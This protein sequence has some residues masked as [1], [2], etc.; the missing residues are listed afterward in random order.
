MMTDLKNV[1]GMKSGKLMGI[2]AIYDFR[3]DQDTGIGNLAIRRIPCACNGCLEQLDSVWKT[4]TVDKE[5]R[6]CKTSD[7]DKMKNIFDGLN[8]W[9]M[10]KLET[11][12]NDDINEGD[13]AKD[14]LH[15][16]ES[17]MS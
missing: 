6:R 7:R 9:Q 17:R 4:G 2:S 13:I 1:I 8:N 12:K 3:S 15:G 11:I 16:I 5:Q 14:I 10:V